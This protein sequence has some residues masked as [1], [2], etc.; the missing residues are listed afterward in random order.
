MDPT[1]LGLREAAPKNNHRCKRCGAPWVSGR[2]LGEGCR[3]ANRV[4]NR[5]RSPY[6]RRSRR[7]RKP[8]S[9][10]AEPAHGTS[11]TGAAGEGVICIDAV[12]PVADSREDT[13]AAKKPRITTELSSEP[14]ERCH[15]MQPSRSPTANAK[16]MPEPM[17]QLDA[18]GVSW[19]QLCCLPSLEELFRQ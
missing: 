10:R 18:C 6:S 3:N 4:R 13:S 2:C 19:A 12:E 7:R 8:G 16:T 14:L 5:D 9:A 11:S 1:H 15:S 17:P